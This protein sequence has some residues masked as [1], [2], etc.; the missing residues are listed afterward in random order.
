MYSVELSTKAQDFLNKLDIKERERIEKR[1]KNLEN[2]PFPSDAK[3][4]GRDNG[5]KVFRYRLGYFRAL[6]KVKEILKIVLIAKIDKR[7][8]V[9]N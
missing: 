6:Y 4:I 2:N 1:L 3:F 5:E 7:D 9:Y 8:R